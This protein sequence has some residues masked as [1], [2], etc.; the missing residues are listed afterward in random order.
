[1]QF[2]FI[3]RLWSSLKYECV[4]LH[5]LEDGRQ[6]T[7]DRLETTEDG[8]PSETEN[9]VWREEL[10]KVLQEMAPYLAEVELSELSGDASASSA[11][12]CLSRVRVFS[13]TP[14]RPTARVCRAPASSTVWMDDSWT[15]VGLCAARRRI[16]GRI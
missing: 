1:M 12:S 7:R 14:S 16:A 3:E 10:L 5:D 4:Y 15:M 9:A 2:P 13:G 11:M 8:E 6:K